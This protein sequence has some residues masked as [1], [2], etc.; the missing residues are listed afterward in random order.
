MK[1]KSIQEMDAHSTSGKHQDN[2]QLKASKEIVLL[3]DLPLEMR[4]EQAS[5]P[6]YL[7]RYE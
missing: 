1:M 5:R 2:D 7:D 4:I 3:R 6:L